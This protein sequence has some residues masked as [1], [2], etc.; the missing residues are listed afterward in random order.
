MATTT[1]RDPRNHKLAALARRL[2]QARRRAHFTSP[3]HAAVGM[4]IAGRTLRQYEAGLTEPGALR[5]GLL[6][7][8][9]EVNPG[10]LLGLE[11]W[12]PNRRSA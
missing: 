6:A 5:L 4:P 11:A 9:Y 8:R 10:W 12:K 2:V 1:Q 7:K 3:E